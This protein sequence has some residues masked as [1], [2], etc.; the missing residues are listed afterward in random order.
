MMYF[1]YLAQILRLTSTLL[2]FGKKLNKFGNL[3]VVFPFKVSGNLGK[4]LVLFIK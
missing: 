1:L 3:L 4:L 2:S